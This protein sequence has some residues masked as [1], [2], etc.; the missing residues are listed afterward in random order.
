MNIKDLVINQ[1]QK[2]T[3]VKV[4]MDSLLKELKIDSLSLAEL[5]FELEEQL[6]IRVSDDELMKIKSIKDVVELIEASDRV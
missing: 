1:I 6:K 5:V 3:K 2:Y 4:E